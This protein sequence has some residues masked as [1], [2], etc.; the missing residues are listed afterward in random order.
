MEDDQFSSRNAVFELFRQLYI[1][2][3]KKLAE[4]IIQL[5]ITELGG[6]R[7]TIPSRKDVYRIRRNQQICRYFNGV[8]VPELAFRFNLSE[9][10]IR[11]I[12]NR[13]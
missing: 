9:T 1:R 2:F 12:V 10:Q 5:I 13:Q 6:L 7:I 8:N 3:D 11:R 4:E